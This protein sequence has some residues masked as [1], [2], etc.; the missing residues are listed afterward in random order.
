MSE[1]IADKL[2]RLLE[3]EARA[4]V[5]SRM[6]GLE[7]SSTYYMLMLEKRDEIRELLFGTSCLVELGIQFGILKDDRPKKKQKKKG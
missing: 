4:E 3:E 6:S 7:N 1:D 2:L 5:T